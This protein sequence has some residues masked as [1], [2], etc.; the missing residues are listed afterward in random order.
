[1]AFSNC[2]CR[3]AVRG[4]ALQAMADDAAG[5]SLALGE[6]ADTP[7][8][9]PGQVGGGVSDRHSPPLPLAVR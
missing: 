9:G 7:A 5:V 8:L 3:A 2:A 1:M 4:S 6:V